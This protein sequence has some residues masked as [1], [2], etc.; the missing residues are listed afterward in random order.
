MA[1]RTN[2]ST[3]TS[4][5][6]PSYAISSGD[7]DGNNL[8]KWQHDVGTSGNSAGISIYPLTVGG[9]NDVREY[10]VSNYTNYGGERYSIDFVKD[11]T[12]THFIYDVWVQSP[13]PSAIG[14]LELDMNQVTSNGNTVISAFQCDSGRG[15]WDYSKITNEQSGA[16]GTKWVPSMIPCNLSKWTPNVWYHV[17]ISTQRDNNGDVTYNWVALNGVMSTIATTTFEEQ[18]L[19]WRIG[20]VVVNF[21]LDPARASGAPMIAYVHDLTI[22]RW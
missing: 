14:N 3:P 1:T 10:E 7:L 22:Y 12:T 8:W 5:L 2:T 20:D 13:N 17:Q 19:N 9:Y 15:V 18:A 16:N 11:T 4:I 6:I 21:Q